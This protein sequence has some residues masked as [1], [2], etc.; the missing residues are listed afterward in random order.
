MTD[1][2]GAH[3]ASSESPTGGNAGQRDLASGPRSSDPTEGAQPGQQLARSTQ[4][5]ACTEILQ[6]RP[7]GYRPGSQPKVSPEAFQAEGFGVDNE[8][9]NDW[10]KLSRG[11]CRFFDGH[12]PRGKGL[13]ARPGGPKPDLRGGS[14][15]SGLGLTEE[16]RC[17]HGVSPQ[18]EHAGQ[19]SSET[20]ARRRA[21]V[22][23]WVS[24]DRPSSREGEMAS[25]G[26]P[27][28]AG[29]VPG[30]SSKQ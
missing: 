11:A 1:S 10:W 5:S 2:Q 21:S 19:G 18:E 8:P 7:G 16:I 12:K 29:F 20:C 13:R 30:R 14:S 17:R 25:S 15:K 6:A 9:A 28:Q 26:S 27:L 22:R 23:Q 4:V 24:L 3:G